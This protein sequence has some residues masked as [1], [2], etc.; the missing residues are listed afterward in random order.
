MSLLSN[1][2]LQ[3]HLSAMSV[4]GTLHAKRSP[5]KVIA[6]SRHEF[7]RSESASPG[8]ALVSM[9][10][11]PCMVAMDA[12]LSELGAHAA[13]QKPA[14]RV[15]MGDACI[16]FDVVQGNYAG[17]S[18]RHLQSIASACVAEILGEATSNQM[19]RWQLQPDLRHLLIS[20]LDSRDAAAI[21]QT[22][23]HHGLQL[24]SL[25]PDFCVQWNRYASV[26]PAQ[27]SVFATVNEGYAT[28]AYAQGGAITALSCGP[29]FGGDNSPEN[30]RNKTLSVDER[31]DR[32]L[33]SLGQNPSAVSNFILVTTAP[34]CLPSVSRWKAFDLS[35]ASR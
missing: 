33:A 4:H 25:Q 14:L 5:H 7:N 15:V 9:I 17:A 27:K 35:E 23:A 19:V 24:H 20:C 18:D 11:K 16:H 13:R 34:E 10:G 2:S 28:V 6:R 32:L 22:A 1:R 30:G 31:T 29:C 12:V 26:L 21:T 3:L 8:S